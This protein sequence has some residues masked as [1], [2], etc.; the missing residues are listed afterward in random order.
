MRALLQRRLGLSDPGMGV[1]D[2]M[3]LA[4]LLD[5][6]FTQGRHYA[7]RSVV[8]SA[9]TFTRASDGL[10]YAVQPAVLRATNVPRYMQNSAV[11]RL[12]GILI[13][14]A[15]T[16]III[17]N[18]VYNVANWAFY[19]AP[20]MSDNTSVNLY[21]GHSFKMVWDGFTDISAIV[22]VHALTAVKYIVE[23]LVY[24]NG[25]AV[26]SADMRFQANVSGGA[27]VYYNPT[28][29]HVGSG[30]YLA[31]AVFTGTAVN[32]DVGINVR[33]NKTIYFSLLSCYLAA[34]TN[35]G[36]DFPRSPIP[37]S[38][39]ASITRA[40][41]LLT[42]PGTGN[43]GA[44][45]GTIDVEFVAPCSEPES[46]NNQY[47]LYYSKDANNRFLLYINPVTNAMT[48][49]LLMGG[50]A[51]CASANTSGFARNNTVKLRFV[52]RQT[53]TL[54]GTNY[55]IL[56]NSVNGAAWGQLCASAV[57][58]TGVMDGSGTIYLLHNTV[59]VSHLG[60]PIR[61][62]RIY[63]RAKVGLPGDF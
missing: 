11:D 54:D 18:T 39:G 51:A 61:R 14:G 59:S 41:D 9:L 57:Q 6:D 1:I 32:W 13:E 46:G 62:I 27:A 24:T 55:G 35:E 45:E 20:V 28:F 30:V 10:D 19:S 40:A 2:D 8:A 53:S 60:S 16:N 25:S 7:H 38:T 50:A 22:Q 47:L 29:E 44:T 33:Q 58:P 26:T 52:Y 56:Y 63:N 43:V 36:G 4:P 48:F 15:D 42:I 37:N 3:N 12:N 31:W 17:Q 21:G 5:L 23:A 34:P 49:T